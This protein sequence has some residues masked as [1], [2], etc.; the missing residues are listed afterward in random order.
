M[1]QLYRSSTE[2]IIILFDVRES[3][4]EQRLHRERTAW[5]GYANVQEFYPGYAAL[6]VWLGGAL[7]LS[8]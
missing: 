8:T 2:C 5:R 1:S 4:S 6:I 3:A 7:E